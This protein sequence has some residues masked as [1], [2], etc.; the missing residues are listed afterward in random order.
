MVWVHTT[1]SYQRSPQ[2]SSCAFQEAPP[3]NVWGDFE[4]FEVFC[5]SKYNSSLR[6]WELWTKRCQKNDS[7]GYIKDREHFS[8]LAYKAGQKVRISDAPFCHLGKF[9]LKI[10][11]LSLDFWLSA[12]RRLLLC[13]YP[14]H[15]FC[16]QRKRSCNRQGGAYI[17]LSRRK[18]GHQ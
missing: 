11:N 7:C 15:C 5:G 4:I 12:Q 18:W 3:R 17:F 1:T 9:I 8:V 14:R 2:R 13:T 10:D 6:K 16:S